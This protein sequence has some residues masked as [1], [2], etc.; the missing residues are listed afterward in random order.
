[1]F[2][3]NHS[4]RILHII[5]SL[6]TL[7]KLEHIAIES[8]DADRRRMRIPKE[9]VVDWELKRARETIPAL[10]RLEIAIEDEFENCE[11]VERLL[12]E[13]HL[14]QIKLLDIF[15]LKQELSWQTTVSNYV[16]YGWSIF[17]DSSFTSPCT[18]RMRVPSCDTA[19]FVAWI[20][21]IFQPETLEHQAYCLIAC[22]DHY[23]FRFNRTKNQLHIAEVTGGSS[24]ISYYHVKEE[25]ASGVQTAGD[26]RYPYQLIGTYYTEDGTRTGG[27]RYQFRDVVVNTKVTEEKKSSDEGGEGEGRKDEKPGKQYCEALFTIDFPSYTS[28]Y[29]IE[30]HQYHLACEWMRWFQIYLL[31]Q[32]QPQAPPQPSE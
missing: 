26:N 12:R 20:T 8:I 27:M 5:D 22:P 32:D 16:T 24:L 28:Q 13:L 2:S 30:E 31:L 4:S 9:S 11:N 18:I 6:S 15:S 14:A 19:H 1:M 21:K 7:V 29:M 17:Y 23:M 10:R 3:I 25:D